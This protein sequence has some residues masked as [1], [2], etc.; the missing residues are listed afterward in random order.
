MINFCLRCGI[1]E[2]ELPILGLHIMPDEEH[3]ILVEMCIA[4]WSNLC[5]KLVIERIMFDAQGT[6]EKLGKFLQEG[7]KVVQ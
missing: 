7:K 2:E 3:T 4:C 5:R 1:S 6:I